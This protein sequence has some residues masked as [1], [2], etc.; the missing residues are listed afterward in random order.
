MVPKHMIFYI[1]TIVKKK[2]LGKVTPLFWGHFR[3]IIWAKLPQLTKSKTCH[4]PSTNFNKQ[5][6]REIS[7]ISGIK[8]PNLNVS[9]LVLHMLLH[10][11]L[12]PGV[13]SWMKI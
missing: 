4:W 13:K 11:L 1:Q 5:M 3:V 6:Y 12:K 9:R 8:S 10:N 7:N 2:C